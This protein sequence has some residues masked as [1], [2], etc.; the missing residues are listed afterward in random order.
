MSATSTA[1]H[2][3]GRTRIRH[4]VAAAALAPLLLG[5]A[6]TLASAADASAS[7]VHLAK[8][9]GSCTSWD[10]DYTD[11]YGARNVNIR[12]GPG[13][14]YT[15]FGQVAKGTKIYAACSRGVWTYV[16]IRSGKWAG[17]KAWINGN[18]VNWPTSW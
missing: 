4:R 9:S 13:M 14:G 16:K 3:G 15:A 6:L 5:S 11:V 12:T 7:S 8:K 1:R 18:Y 10:R 2:A 17:Q